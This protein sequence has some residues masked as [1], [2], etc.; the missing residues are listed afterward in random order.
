MEMK[1]KADDSETDAVVIAIDSD[2]GEDE[3]LYF[4]LSPH[5]VHNKNELHP[6]ID[7][8]IESAPVHLPAA[9]IVP[10]VLKRPMY[11]GRT[12]YKYKKPEAQPQP[13]V[14]RVPM[15]NIFFDDGVDEVCNQKKPNMAAVVEVDGDLQRA[16]EASLR[17]DH[18]DYGNDDDYYTDSTTIASSTTTTT[19]LPPPP[20]SNN[21][22]GG[23]G[24][25]G[26]FTPWPGLS[27]TRHDHYNADDDAEL[28]RAIEISL[29]TAVPCDSEDDIDYSQLDPDERE[30]MRKAIDES[31]LEP[32]GEAEEQS[33]SIDTGFAT[34]MEA[35]EREQ[36][37]II[38]DNDTGF[39]TRMREMRELYDER[40]QQRIITG[41]H[42]YNCADPSP[43]NNDT[44]LHIILNHCALQCIA[45]LYQVSRVI[46]DRI[47]HVLYVFP[48][49]SMLVDSIPQLRAIVQGLRHYYQHAVN[50]VS[51]LLLLRLGVA[52]FG[53]SHRG[54]YEL[55]PPDKF[56]IES[57]VWDSH[58]D[59]QPPA[60]LRELCV[61]VA[62]Y[63]DVE[64]MSDY[65][66]CILCAVYPRSGYLLHC[67]DNA[68]RLTLYVN[69]D[70]LSG[71]HRNIIDMWLSS[72][73][74]N[75][76]PHIVYVQDDRSTRWNSMDNE[77]YE[78]DGKSV[79]ST[80]S[81]TATDTQSVQS[82]FLNDGNSVLDDALDE[83]GFGLDG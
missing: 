75:T 5:S 83:S 72:N 81:T 37:R 21:N 78:C 14:H 47:Y 34:R 25:G 80:E 64:I 69:T 9:P 52:W 53:R 61:R 38:T 48:P 74:F 66:M 70:N 77:M 24:G 28:Q 41:N 17:W 59:S 43:F 55:Q 16:I 33:S 46:R 57:M 20:H 18:G 67:N 15:D 19:G 32:V 65:V 71:K 7:E 4:S 12:L 26:G 76:V 30:A 42:N 56:A 23:G 50:R 36:Q 51:L 1:R 39:V 8:T 22:K 29:K 40:E 27:M 35:D 82:L 11:T 63:E 79:Y 73:Y 45:S 13:Y 10:V 3:L 54:R 58:R 60:R 31:K 62:S 68:P 6:L 49:R 44:A 2:E